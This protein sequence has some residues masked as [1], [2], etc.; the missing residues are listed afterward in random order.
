MAPLPRDRIEQSPLPRDRI[1]QSPPFAATG[2]DF[3]I[4]FEKRT[5]YRV[6]YSDNAK[7]VKRAEIQLRR[8]WTLINHPDVK[9]FCA[10]RG[11]KWKYIIERGAWWD[12]FCERI[13]RSV[14]TILPKVIGK[15]SLAK[16]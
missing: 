12:G 5:L 13:V 11:I 1:E 16:S 9:E 4:Y 15:S 7:T 8:L 3:A 14:K 10:S 6:I 2:L